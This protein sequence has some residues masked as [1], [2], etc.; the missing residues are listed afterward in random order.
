MKWLSWTIL[1]L[2]KPLTMS[3]TCNFNI[4]LILRFCTFSPCGSLWYPWV[5]YR[6]ANILIEVVPTSTL[7]YVSSSM[8]VLQLTTLSMLWNHW[9]F[10]NSTSRWC[11]NTV[12]T[13][14]KESKK[15]MKALLIP[16]MICFS[17]LS[18][19][20]DFS[21]Q[22]WVIITEGLYDRINPIPLN[23]S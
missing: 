18:L 10:V 23:V 4:E 7:T 1:L 6:L 20:N 16:S 9:K 5:L 21:F 11:S 22:G 15:Y 8:Y 3:D 12:Y 13:R 17:P 14:E 2:C 19:N